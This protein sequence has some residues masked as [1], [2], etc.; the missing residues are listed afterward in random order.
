MD[1]QQQRDMYMNMFIQ[2]PVQ[3][4]IADQA[5][6]DDDLNERDFDLTKKTNMNDEFNY[7][8]TMK[9]NAPQGKNF[10]STVSTF[11][12]R[13]GSGNAYGSNQIGDGIY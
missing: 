5:Q 8:N 3:S 2:Q 4:I 7:S 12:D 13:D 1:S 9:S 6:Q 11:N 10:R